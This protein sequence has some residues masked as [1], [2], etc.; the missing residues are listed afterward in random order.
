MKN[1]YK[2]QPRK[3]AILETEHAKDWNDESILG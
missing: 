2:F 1:K 3:T